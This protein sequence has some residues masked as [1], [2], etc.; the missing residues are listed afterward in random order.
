MFSKSTIFAGL[1]SLAVAAPV[2]QDS[3]TGQDEVYQVSTA[4]AAPAD[5]AAAPGTVPV[6]TVAQV[7][8][9]VCKTAPAKD[10]VQAFKDDCA[11]TIISKY[12]AYNPPAGYST[13]FYNHNASNN[14]PYGYMTYEQLP[15]GYDQDH[16]ASQC[17]LIPGCESFNIYFERDPVQ[18]PT[19]A[20]P[21]PQSNWYGV[22]AL[23]FTNVKC[24]YYS[25]ILSVASATNTG[26]W[27]DQFQVAIAGS[28]AY[29]KNS[30][31]VAD[32][33]YTPAAGTK[34][35]HIAS[36]F[37]INAPLDCNGDDTLAGMQWW[38][39]GQFQVERCAQACTQHTNY[40][41]ANGGKQCSFFNTFLQTTNGNV[42]QQMCTFYDETWDV[43]Q[44]AV[45]YGSADGSVVVSESYAFVSN[46]FTGNPSCATPAGQPVS[47]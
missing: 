1:L 45:N 8:G 17:N 34:A 3:T 33:G 22:G 16:C 24:A 42:A 26:Q 21:N 38:N 28:N 40:V 47:Q 10:T 2:A 46:S 19:D 25:S 36:D 39:D 44:Y 37:A 11:Y 32:S 6:T 20:C 7:Q 41:N 23:G 18:D 13:V 35:G 14:A 43:N 4:P 12:Q 31:F 27:R 9:P 5:Q 15:K 29:V 30:L